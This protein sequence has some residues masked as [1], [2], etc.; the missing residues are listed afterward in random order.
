MGLRL[1]QLFV[2]T[3]NENVILL[4]VLVL[5]YGLEY[6]LGY[7]QPESAEYGLRVRHTNLKDFK[8]MGKASLQYNREQKY[9]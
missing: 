6:G 8:R 1:S 7:A 2:Q 9:A 4:I 3:N 5:R